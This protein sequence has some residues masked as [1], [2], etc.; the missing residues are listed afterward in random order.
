MFRLMDSLPNH[1]NM[2]NIHLAPEAP[3]QRNG[4]TYEQKA[5]KAKTTHNMLKGKEAAI[6]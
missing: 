1:S 3:R 4:C 6:D 5:I 2:Q